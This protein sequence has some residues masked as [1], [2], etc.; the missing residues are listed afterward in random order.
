MDDASE[1][2]AA[3]KKRFPGMEG[4]DLDDICY[5]TQ[6]RQT[7]VRQLAKEIDLL[8]VVGARN[9][10]NSIRLREVGEQ[11]GVTA[12]LIHDESEIEASWLVGA[13]KVGVTAG[14]SAPEVLVQRV[15]ERLRGFGVTTT[16]ELEGVRETVTFSLPRVLLE[17]GK[18]RPSLVA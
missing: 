7:A 4:P 1:V 11:H 10:S 17:Q 8:L 3:L 12:H 9:S 15:L 6:N 13:D 2:I 14:A 16:R 5:A 18:Q